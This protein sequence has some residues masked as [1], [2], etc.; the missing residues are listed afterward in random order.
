MSS[1]SFL[2]RHWL[3]VEMVSCYLLFSFLPPVSRVIKPMIGD[4]ADVL[5]IIGYFWPYPVLLT[6]QAWPTTQKLWPA[7]ILVG[8]VLVLGFAEML[9]SKFR[10]FAEPKV[11]PGMLAAVLWYV[12]IFSAQGLLALIIWSLGYPI[13]E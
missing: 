6:L 12:P 2:K 5:Q 13:G 3:S 7:I 10:V 4:L 8:L 11:L 9:Q 1:D